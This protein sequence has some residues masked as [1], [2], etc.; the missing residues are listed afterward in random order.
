[1]GVSIPASDISMSH[2]TFQDFPGCNIKPKKTIKAQNLNLFLK[3]C[4]FP[5]QLHGN[6]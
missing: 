2:T 1:M 6:W 5:P 3:S 4:C